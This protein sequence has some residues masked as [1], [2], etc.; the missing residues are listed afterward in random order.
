MQRS[1]SFQ[2]ITLL[3]LIAVMAMLLSA[4]AL[5]PEFT[6]SISASESTDDMATEMVTVTHPQGETTVVR[7]PQTIVVFNYSALDTL[8]QLGIPVTGVIQG[9]LMPPN[10]EKY[11]GDEYVNVGSMREPDYEKVNELNPDLI[12]VGLR[13]S[14]LYE[15]MAKIAPTLDVTVDWTN[16][17]ETF[18]DYM[19]NI[20]IIFDKEAEVAERLAAIDQRILDVREQAEA[21]GATALIVLSS[22]GEVSGYGPGSRFGLIHD[23]LGVAHTTDTMVAETHGDTISFEFILEQNPDILY[24]VDRDAAIGAEGEAAAQVMDNE[25]VEGTTAGANDNIVYLNSINWYLVDAGL[26]AFEMM[27]DEVASGLQ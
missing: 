16:K 27:I 24:V 9:P 15:E 2:S 3:S 19:T 21:S 10:L 18:K 7:N 17:Y 22:G 20:G 8:D 26:S 1:T 14:P 12:I 23:M 13:T 25:L 5:T 4:C 6:D 11:N